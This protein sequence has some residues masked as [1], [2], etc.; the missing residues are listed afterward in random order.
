MRCCHLCCF[1]V[2]GRCDRQRDLGHWLGTGDPD[3]V[4]GTAL[5]PAGL[6]PAFDSGGGFRHRGAAGACRSDIRR[7]ED[8]VETEA[9]PQAAGETSKDKAAGR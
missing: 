5:F 8:D 2:V 6:D 4:D 1:A 9:A 3:P 7:P